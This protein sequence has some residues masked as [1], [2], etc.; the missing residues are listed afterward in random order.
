[1]SKPTR[2]LY[3]SILIDRRVVALQRDLRRILR[4]YRRGTLSRLQCQVQGEA[5]INQ[6]YNVMR[7]DIKT[8]LQKHGLLFMGDFTVLEQRLMETLTRWRKITDD[9]N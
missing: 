4:F 2:L 7:S 9:F 3:P 6:S 1:M 8:Y 5:I